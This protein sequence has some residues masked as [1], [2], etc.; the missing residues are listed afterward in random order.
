LGRALK[1]REGTVAN[2]YQEFLDVAADLGLP[3]PGSAL[4]CE[5]PGE[6]RL[7]LDVKTRQW[8]EDAARSIWSALSVASRALKK[9]QAPF[10]GHRPRVGVM[11]GGVRPVVHPVSRSIY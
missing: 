9:W 1:L 10:R 3:K 8:D 5:I 11:W 7:D 4:A 2:F 6:T